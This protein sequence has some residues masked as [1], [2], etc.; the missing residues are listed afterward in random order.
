MFL[1]IPMSGEWPGI[2]FAVWDGAAVRR[3]GLKSVGD[4]VKLALMSEEAASIGEHF[5]NAFWVAAFIAIVAFTRMWS[6]SL[7]SSQVWVWTGI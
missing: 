7:V 5:R 2:A 1:Q 3:R 4:S 6:A